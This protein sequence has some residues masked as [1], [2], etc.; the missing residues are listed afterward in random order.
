MYPL[1]LDYMPY[2]K[3]VSFIEF[4][5]TCCM[6]DNIVGKILSKDKNMSHF[7]LPKVGQT[8]HVVKT[9]FLR[10]NHNYIKFLLTFLILQM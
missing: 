1:F 4:L 9:G 8:L 3:S 5:M 10:P 2:M 6:Y 7:K